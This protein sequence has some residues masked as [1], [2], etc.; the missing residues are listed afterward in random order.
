MS[1]GEGDDVFSS[2]SL[3]FASFK[4]FFMICPMSVGYCNLMEYT[5]W[6]IS[7]HELQKAYI[8]FIPT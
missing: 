5:K 4:P 7:V 6:N 2:S 8:N 1:M 3:R